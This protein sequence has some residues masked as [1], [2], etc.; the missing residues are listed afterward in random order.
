MWAACSTGALLGL[1]FTLCAQSRPAVP[2]AA[3]ARGGGEGSPTLLAR[4]GEAPFGKTPS[5]ISR[6]LKLFCVLT[7]IKLVELSSVLH[8]LHL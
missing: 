2:A 7:M 3:A 6:V 5:V 8:K 1:A 4:A